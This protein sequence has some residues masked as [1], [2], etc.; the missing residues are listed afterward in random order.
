MIR[1]FIACG[2]AFLA[3]LSPAEAADTA[4]QMTQGERSAGYEVLM[5][6]DDDGTEVE[7][8]G[9]FDLLKSEARW[10]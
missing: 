8:V 1:F 2:A 9:D 3:P 4:V 6:D 5:L 7:V 10:A